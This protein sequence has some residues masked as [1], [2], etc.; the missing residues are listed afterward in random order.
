MNTDQKA[1]RNINATRTVSLADAVVNGYAVKRPDGY[2]SATNGAKLSG[3]AITVHV[4]T[5]AL[6]N[7]GV[8]LSH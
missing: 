6:V 7:D 4:N 2:Y 1:A 5:G 8:A 3:P